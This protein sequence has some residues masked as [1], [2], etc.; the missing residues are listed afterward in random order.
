MKTIVTTQAVKL[1][2][3]RTEW[4]RKNTIRPSGEWHQRGTFVSALGI[5]TI[6]Y[7]S[8]SVEITTVLNGTEHKM[9][10]KGSVTPVG[11]SIR[12]GKFLKKLNQ[13]QNG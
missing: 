1:H 6:F 4:H 10:I 5:C 7:K 11:V 8:S 9:H 3:N 13:S 2:K 12:C